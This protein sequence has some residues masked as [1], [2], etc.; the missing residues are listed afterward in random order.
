MDQEQIARLLDLIDRLRK[1]RDIFY[2]AYGIIGMVIIV[3]SLDSYLSQSDRW[4]YVYHILV[5]LL[6][7]W[8]NEGRLNKYVEVQAIREEIRQYLTHAM[9]FEN[10]LNTVLKTN[11]AFFREGCPHSLDFN[12]N[13][14]EIFAEMWHTPSNIWFVRYIEKCFAYFCDDVESKGYGKFSECHDYASLYDKCKD[15]IGSTESLRVELRAFSQD[16]LIKEFNDGLQKTVGRLTHGPY[17]QLV[18]GLTARY[19][20]MLAMGTAHNAP[21]FE[22]IPIIFLTIISF[23]LFIFFIMPIVRLSYKSPLM[24]K[25]FNNEVVEKVIGQLKTDTAWFEKY[26]NIG[27]W[28]LFLLFIVALSAVVSNRIPENN[29]AYTSSALVIIVFSIFYALTV[30]YNRNTRANEKS[31]ANSICRKFRMVLSGRFS[32][33]NVL[34]GCIDFIID[35]NGTQSRK[36]RN[37]TNAT[38]AI[39]SLKLCLSKAG[40]VF[41][42]AGKRKIRTFGLAEI[43]SLNAEKFSTHFK[44][45]Y[46]KLCELDKV[47]HLF[48]NLISKDFV[49]DIIPGQENYLPTLSICFSSLHQDQIEK[50]KKLQELQIFHSEKQDGSFTLMIGFESSDCSCIEKKLRTLFPPNKM[51]PPPVFQSEPKKRGDR[52]RRG[53]TP[54]AAAAAVPRE[55]VTVEMPTISWP[56]GSN[57]GRDTRIIQELTGL[58]L[59]SQRC[60][61]QWDLVEHSF[62]NDRNAYDRFKEIFD[63]AK[64][65]RRQGS[66]GFV[67]WQETRSRLI[68]GEVKSYT[69]TMKLKALGNQGNARCYCWHETS[70][71]GRTLYHVFDYDPYTH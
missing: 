64:L 29:K 14:Y 63:D 39:L 31:V 44:L 45:C 43:S 19:N 26:E 62:G 3:I 40:V 2:N 10:E 15:Y 16:P 54:A 56:S 46:E 61:V 5:P 12:R 49:M 66:Q 70:A 52:R 1:R 24:Q 25:V 71:C 55:R 48:F 33:L 13:P 7:D 34:D 8:W 23:L 65:V 38:N 67:R 51:K 50:L 37:P 27:N 58:G 6:D 11:E 60:F 41:I 59:P 22:Y 21:I 18:N 35:S 57:W 30:W 47:E 4:R 42:D 69:C 20:K 17:V 68:S 28:I 36:S 9:P 32:V 53:A